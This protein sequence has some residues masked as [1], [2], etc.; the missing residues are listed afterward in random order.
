MLFP[1][2]IT[3]TDF[4]GAWGA[5]VVGV[6]VGKWGRNCP[7]LDLCLRN[8]TGT[9]DGEHLELH[10]SDGTIIDEVNYRTSAPWPQLTAQGGPSIYLKALNA[11][12][13][14]NPANW[15]ASAPGV[16][17]ARNNTI[18]EIFNRI[19]AG[20]PA[21]VSTGAIMSMTSS[22]AVDA[23]QATWGGSGQRAFFD[24]KPAQETMPQMNT[25][26]AP[27]STADRQAV[28]ALQERFA[29]RSTVPVRYLHQQPAPA[30]VTAAVDE[31]LSREAAIFQ[32]ATARPAEDFT[33][34]RG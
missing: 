21:T 11:V 22:R 16:A 12:A 1:D 30:G 10:R 14:D 15:S 24:L 28:S 18:T 33:G 3:L 20:S 34:N 29:V 27:F 13:N 4:R 32:L 25:S 26:P 19:D 17:G 6:S 23:N 9:G 7:A 5:N 2:S 8:S 31:L